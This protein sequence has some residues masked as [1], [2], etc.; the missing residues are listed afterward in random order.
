MVNYDLPWNP[1]RAGAALRTYPPNGQTEV[2]HLWNLVSADTR[3]GEVYAT[4]E[5]LNA[6]QRGTSRGNVFRCIL[7]GATYPGLQGSM[8]LNPIRRAPP[9][10]NES[11]SAGCTLKPPRLISS[12]IRPVTQM[13]PCSSKRLCSASCSSFTSFDRRLTSSRKSAYSFRVIVA[14]RNAVTI[15]TT[16]ITP[17]MTAVTSCES[18]SGSR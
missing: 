4:A 16:N 15:N 9:S 6:A 18:F 8:R 17:R 3:E 11:T 5:E 12:L 7:T 13:R 2:C 1:N 14:F 10:S